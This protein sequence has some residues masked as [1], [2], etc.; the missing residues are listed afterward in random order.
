MLIESR[1]KSMLSCS[2]SYSR[3]IISYVRSC[4]IRIMWSS[5]IKFKKL[6]NLKVNA[7]PGRILWTRWA[8]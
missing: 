5:K 6:P 3:T 2:V 4:L 7:K 8:T 1:K